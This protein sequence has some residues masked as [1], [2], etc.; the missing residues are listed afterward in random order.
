MISLKY[1]VHA[2]NQRD[3]AVLQIRI[4]SGTGG[5]NNWTALNDEGTSS[6]PNKRLGV[7]WYNNQVPLGQPGEIDPGDENQFFWG[8]TDTAS[9]WQTAR[10]PLDGYLNRTVQFRIAFGSDAANIDT[11]DGFAFD[12]VFVGERDRLVLLEQFTNSMAPNADLYG[13]MDGNELDLNYLEFHTQP[14]EIYLA[15]PGPTNTRGSVYNFD[16]VPRSFLGGYYDFDGSSGNEL[17]PYNIVNEA[18]GDPV[19]AISADT[20]SENDLITLSIDVQALDTTTSRMVLHTAIVEKEFNNGNNVL[21]NIVRAMIP[22]PGGQV[23]ELSTP[24]AIESFEYQFDINDINLSE[25]AELAAVIFVQNAPSKGD[26]ENWV[27]QS[28]LVDLPDVS[29]RVITGIDDTL[30]DDL[31]MNLY[32]NPAKYDAVL[33]FSRVL[34]KPYRW[35]ISDLRGVEL[36]AGTLPQGEELFNLDL[37]MLP[38]GVFNVLISDDNDLV[39]VRKLMI[40]R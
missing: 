22:D 10:F 8:W 15:N 30:W 14:D 17:Q 38:T 13:M 26:Q 3:G 35:K 2:E 4:T 28:I 9:F 39:T 16:Q 33:K 32:P 23:F 36:A 29:E 20:L 37:T 19:F 11:V 24:G 25:N 18:M 6:D 7:N 34:E 5:D 31:R 12:D 27:Y 21:R 40:I 1:W